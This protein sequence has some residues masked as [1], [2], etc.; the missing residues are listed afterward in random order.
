MPKK[1]RDDNNSPKITN[2]NLR[3][4]KKKQLKKKCNKDSDSDSDSSSDY[5]PKDDKMEDMNP[6]ELK[7]L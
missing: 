5:D 1:P 2:Y 4:R 6:R 7:D 3:R